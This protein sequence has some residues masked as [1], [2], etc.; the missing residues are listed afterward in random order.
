MKRLISSIIIKLSVAVVSLSS[1]VASHG[2]FGAQP[3]EKKINVHI[4][5][6][7]T[8][9]HTEGAVAFA[10]L[11]KS[12]TA[13]TVQLEIHPGGSLGLKGEEVLR[14]VRQG[15]VPMAEVLMG[16][17]EGENPV[18][19]LTSLPMVAKNFDDAKKLY[20]Y[21]TATVR[22]RL[23]RRLDPCFSTLLRGLQGASIPKKKSAP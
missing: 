20:E 12:K 3:A 7:A 10:A 5:W 21:L 16:N 6:P 18:F 23:Q 13:G 9:F 19:G 11:V 4:A 22:E 8:N 2:A 14:A 15:S 17:V 1:V